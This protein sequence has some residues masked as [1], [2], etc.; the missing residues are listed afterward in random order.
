LHQESDKIPIT[1]IKEATCT[2]LVCWPS[3]GS[4]GEDVPTVDAADLK[5][6]WNMYQ[7]LEQR[8]PGKQG[9][10]DIS[11]IEKVC[12]P[13][14]DL[15]AVTHRSSMLQ[16]VEMM[17]A[18]LPVPWRANEETPRRCVQGR[19]ANTHE[20]DGSGSS[21][22]GFAVRC[23]GVSSGRAQRVSAV[24]QRIPRAELLLVFLV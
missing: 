16:L 17:R 10:V 21:T 9:A 3:G 20:M 7:E 14:T 15:G 22:A 23:K 24:I 13:G 2:S 6:L 19:G 1:T 4:P 18:K 11:L 5:S 12:S 8:H